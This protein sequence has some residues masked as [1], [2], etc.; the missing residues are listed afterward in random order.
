MESDGTTGLRLDSN[1]D[2][3]A[4]FLRS[5][6]EIIAVRAEGFGIGS[7]D[8]YGKSWDLKRHHSV[9]KTT[10]QTASS[11]TPPHPSLGTFIANA[12]ALG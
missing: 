8:K 12:R 6:S 9:N 5:L 10:G 3:V 7:W 1:K 11:A 4:R 2:F